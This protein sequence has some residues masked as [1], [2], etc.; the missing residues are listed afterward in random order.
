MSD[1]LIKTVGRF[2]S[3]FGVILGL[4][5]LFIGGGMMLPVA[6]E[7][8][9][10]GDDVIELVVS[11][12]AFLALGAI[13]RSNSTIGDTRPASVFAGVA[14]TWIF[15]SVLGALPYILTG[16]TERAGVGFGTEMADAIFESVSGFTCTGS[17][18]LTNLPDLGDPD[19]QIG[20][21]VLLWRQLTQWFG[22][23]GIV[24][25]V[26]AVL[27][28][29]G[30]RG[31]GF[32]AAE[33]PGPAAGRLVPRLS[34]TAKRLWYVYTAVTVL[35]A[36]LYT[37]AGMGLYDAFQHAFTTA[38]TGG[39][40]PYNDSV[41]EFDS[42][43]IEMAAIAGMVI[44]GINFSLHYRTLFRRDLGAYARDHETRSYLT[45]LLV[46]FVLIML[47]LWLASPFSFGTSVRT[48]AFNTAT[49]GTSTGFGNAQGA[50]TPGDFVQ[51]IPSGQMVLLVLMFIGGCTGS[52]SGGLK[53]G[54]FRVMGLLTERSLRQARHPHAV[55]P[56]K[57]G[58]DVVPDNMVNGIA[59]FTLTY[60]AFASAGTV[61]VAMLGTDFLTALGGAVGSMGN[62]GPALNNVGPTNTFLDSFSL[63]A[64]MVLAFLM[65]VGRLEVFAIALMFTRP[66]RLLRQRLPMRVR[67]Y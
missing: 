20:R 21:G 61:L 63:T 41:G 26:L 56:V 17:T 24:A 51:W 33:A 44:G 40:S 32:L 59:G 15:V 16:I 35:I 47:P 5:L 18:V 60:L 34:E 45:I 55:I 57:I 22:G 67:R 65:I 3:T 8:I 43:P 27:P 31:V 62:M 58:R 48:A 23:M 36:L 64:R 37:L 54:R 29:M 66:S 52:T 19:P 49:L 7:I 50:G 6:V 13:I 53:V 10:G 14:G 11:A 30:V 42:V 12:A 39:F 2:E 46:A 9:S 25:L 4:A 1:P 28:A 38:A